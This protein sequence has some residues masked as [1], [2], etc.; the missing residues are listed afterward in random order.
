M[1][2]T[3]FN[4]SDLEVTLNYVRVLLISKFYKLSRKYKKNAQGLFSLVGHT[5][6]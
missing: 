6:C 5:V 3:H 4:K 1:N 2:R